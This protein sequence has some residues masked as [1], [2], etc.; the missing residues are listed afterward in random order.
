MSQHASAPHPVTTAS[1]L[2]AWPARA[3]FGRVLPKSKIY[4]HSGANT[5]LKKRFSEEIEQIIWQYK[6]APETLQLPPHP[7]VA[8]IQIF[9]IQLKTPRLHPD[10]L[11]CI[12]SAIPFPIIFELG[13]NDHTQVTAAHKRPNAADP[14]RRVLS[15]YF[16]S[17]WH[18]AASERTG[19]PIAL[20]LGGLYEQLL[21]RLIPLQARP[22]E[23]L[24]V[25]LARAA[26]VR[27]KQRELKQATAR[28]AKEKQFNRKV[29]L[30]AAVRQ[31][32]S[33]LASL[34][35]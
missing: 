13:F 6:L 3:A 30:N 17:A 15:D 32:K 9:S 8:E 21:R 33:E 7:E 10:I 5:R 25:L 31:L 24:A 26:Q 1:T 29:E 28:L 22:Q 23:P 18:A 11:R 27:T 16:A 12:D 20:H 19:L 34:S 35:R 14:A 2:T 4:A